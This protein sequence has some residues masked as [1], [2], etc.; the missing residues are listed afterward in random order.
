MTAQNANR[1]V[2]SLLTTADRLEQ[3]TNG[4]EVRAAV[5]DGMLGL[6]YHLDTLAR[7]LA[8][9]PNQTGAFEPELRGRALKVESALRALLVRAWDLLA[10]TDVALD[11]PG[12]AVN[13]ARDLR[14]AEHAEISLVFD[15][16]LSP[17]AID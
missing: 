1:V 15:Q 5:R 13:L 9:D 11:E 3:T 16:L 14:A 12:L 2:E 10:M 8:R 6:E 17:Q 7:E 4:F